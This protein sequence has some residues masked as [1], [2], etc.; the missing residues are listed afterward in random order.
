MA[1]LLELGTALRTLPTAEP[2]QRAR[3][4]AEAR[5]RLAEA[6]NKVA[7]L[8]QK[9]ADAPGS[10]GPEVVRLLSSGFAEID[11]LLSQEPPVD[12]GGPPAVAS[13]SLN[14]GSTTLAV[15]DTTSWVAIARDREGREVEGRTVT[16][17]SADPQVASVSPEGRITGISPGKAMIRVE[18]E[19]QVV[20]Q[21][22]NV[23]LAPAPPA[24]PSVT[25]PGEAV[26]LLN[27]ARAYEARDALPNAL[28]SYR[29]ALRVYPE[30]REAS[31]GLTR[32][33]LKL[34]VQDWAN[35]LSQR[36]LTGLRQMYPE[37]T[38]REQAAWRRLL[39]NP[40]VTRLV[41]VPRDVE[42]ELTGETSA[43][44]RYLLVYTVDSRPGGR[45]V[46]TSRYQTT[47]R[48]TRGAWLITSMRGGP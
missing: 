38:E 22:V 42:V 33:T 13:V 15:G 32:V 48:L 36:S 7:A 19:G 45:K 11:Q 17:R 18:V 16:W 44:V 37:M 31:D 5:L 43:M 30:Y 1:A 20:S 4:A 23:T 34:R 46:S 10:V 29:D 41:A 28:D 25:I 2:D 27:R 9:F 26:N 47:F 6:R 14:A 21:Q 35:H 40:S 39:E 3:R 8:Q 12:R 24:P